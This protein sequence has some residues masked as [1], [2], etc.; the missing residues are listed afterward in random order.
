MARERGKGP[1]A[2]KHPTTDYFP[3]TGSQPAEAD[4]Q[5]SA[6]Q[7]RGEVESGGV[8]EAKCLRVQ[9]EVRRLP[10]VAAHVRDQKEAKDD[11]PLERWSLPSLRSHW[12]HRVGMPEPTAAVSWDVGTTTSIGTR[13]S[14]TGTARPLGHPGISHLHLT[15]K[16]SLSLTSAVAF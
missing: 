11:R 15:L 4:P 6:E 12:P 16:L 14:P 1:P 3:A 7:Q 8:S 13:W 9:E 10:R 5:P 2:V